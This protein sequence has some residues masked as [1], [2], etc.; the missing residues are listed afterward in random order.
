MVLR[1]LV[2][3]LLVALGLSAVIAASA[4]AMY[5]TPVETSP[6]GWNN[7]YAAVVTGPPIFGGTLGG[8]VHFNVTA[9]EIE[10]VETVAVENGNLA[11][12]TG[13]L[14]FTGVS[15]SEPVHCKSASSIETAALTGTFQMGDTEATSGG[16]YV[17]FVPTS[18]EVL[19]TIKLEGEGCTA[20]GSYQLKGTLYAKAANST[21]TFAVWQG[22]SFS[23]AINSS[24]GGALLIGK[25][26]ASLEAGIKI[27]LKGEKEFE[28]VE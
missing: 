28:V 9:T 18:G 17:K 20:A 13:K 7:P 8:G 1:K 16:L 10:G 4:Q 25:E 27:G 14:K 11:Q 3:M 24:Q 19:L 5:A 21:G 12:L 15:V 23:K 6:P 22:L 2:A 26:A